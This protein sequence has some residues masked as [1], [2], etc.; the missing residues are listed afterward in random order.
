MQVREVAKLCFERVALRSI[1]S[2]RDHLKC[3][4]P[5]MFWG[6]NFERDPHYPFCLKAVGGVDANVTP[7][8]GVNFPDANEQS[9]VFFLRLFGVIQM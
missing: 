8:A 4:V 6:S 9:G 2:E 1:K 7:V 5:M 3:L